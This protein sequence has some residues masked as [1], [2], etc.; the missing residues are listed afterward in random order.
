M[1]D[2]VWVCGCLSRDDAVSWCVFGV[3]RVVCGCR[4]GEFG[5]LRVGGRA[6]AERVTMLLLVINT[7]PFAIVLRVQLAN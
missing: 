2:V 7:L 1:G 3:C 5:V 6:G 4:G